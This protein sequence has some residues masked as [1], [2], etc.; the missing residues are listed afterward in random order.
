M[1]GELC[2]FCVYFAKALLCGE[3]DAIVSTVIELLKN[4]RKEK[5]KINKN[6]VVIKKG[7][8]VELFDGLNQYIKGV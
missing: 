6:G 1:M 8:N 3:G 4:K 5:R 2:L 7:K